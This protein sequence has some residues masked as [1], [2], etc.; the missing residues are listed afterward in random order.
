M[1]K[2]QCLYRNERGHSAQNSTLYMALHVQYTYI[3]TTAGTRASPGLLY[4]H[5]NDSRAEKGD[6]LLT[7]KQD[8][9]F[10]TWYQVG[11]NG[12]SPLSNGQL[13][14]CAC[15]KIPRT[16]ADSVGLFN[17]MIISSVVGVWVC[18][19]ICVSIDVGPSYATERNGFRP[20]ARLCRPLSSGTRHLYPRPK[21]F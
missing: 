9:H 15:E 4:F 7:S 1:Y 2:R 8:T 14:A 21:P 20:R 3:E 18:W 5:R 17:L 12:V 6:K 10:R 13:Y 16:F 19:C 11:S